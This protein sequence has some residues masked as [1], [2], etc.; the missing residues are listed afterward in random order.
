MKIYSKNLKRFPIVLFIFLVFCFSVSAQKT[1][2]EKCLSYEPAVVK[3][4][5]KLSRKTVTNASE[6][7]ETIWVLT[8]DKAVCVDADAENEFNPAF[9]R[10]TEVQ[11][12]LKSEQIR[13]FRALQNQNISV[14]GTLFAGHTQHHF[15]E[16]LIMVAGGEKSAA[17]N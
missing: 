16:V 9:E 15:T 6:Q 3:L 5:G 11:L 13:K 14:T 4:N 12:V 1:A 2:A 7:K 17:K 10:I 8:L